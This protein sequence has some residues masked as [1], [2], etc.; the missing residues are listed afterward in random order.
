MPRPF[1]RQV[2]LFDGVE[3]FVAD[4]RDLR[5]CIRRQDLR[6][7]FQG[8]P[9]L[10]CSCCKLSRYRQIS[11][12]MHYRPQLTIKLQSKNK[13]FHAVEAQQRLT[14]RHGPIFRVHH[15]PSYRTQH[16]FSAKVSDGLQQL[17]MASH[18]TMAT[19]LPRHDT[20]PES[21]VAVSVAFAGACSCSGRYG[22]V[23]RTCN[24]TGWRKFERKIKGSTNA[25]RL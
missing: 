6:D 12:C 19:P 25:H 10:S 22:L 16:A 5:E 14:C 13:S 11:A 4:T 21:D 15:P 1:E 24:E 20:E 18:F 17:S 9:C 8:T 23:C 7:S 3:C 2:G